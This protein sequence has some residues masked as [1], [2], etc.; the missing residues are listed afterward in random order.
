VLV[1]TRQPHQQ[2]CKYLHSPIHD[3]HWLTCIYLNI[4]WLFPSQSSTFRKI[5]FQNL[6][7]FIH[8]YKL[9][10]HFSDE[11]GKNYHLIFGQILSLKLNWFLYVKMGQPLHDDMWKSYW[12]NIV[13]TCFPTMVDGRKRYKSTGIMMHCN[14]LWQL[15]N[16]QHAC[17]G[18]QLSHTQMC[19][20]LACG[21]LCTDVEQTKVVAPCEVVRY[22][23]VPLKTLRI[24]RQDL[25]RLQY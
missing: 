6:I 25:W 18:F 20:V 9:I 3:I 12:H 16:C 10:L 21:V 5:P 23:H 17:T 2:K 14:Y 13:A 24:D 11:L 4:K 15:F 19:F 1:V 22:V 8:D 7:N